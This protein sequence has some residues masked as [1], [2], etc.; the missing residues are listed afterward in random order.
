MMRNLIPSYKK[1][2]K[3]IICDLNFIH[4]KKQKFKPKKKLKLNI[5]NNI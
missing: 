4:R 3:I 1:L 2:K 5:P